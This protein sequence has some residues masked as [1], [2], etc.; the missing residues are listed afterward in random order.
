MTTES[1]P[2]PDLAE[3]LQFC[4]DSDYLSSIWTQVRRDYPDQYVAVYEGRIV[5]ADGT[6]R[7]VLKRMDS[8]GVPKNHT[9]LRFASKNPRR[10]IL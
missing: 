3:H 4:K 5:A 7:G 9:V 2:G 1:I 8:E 6:L 10:M